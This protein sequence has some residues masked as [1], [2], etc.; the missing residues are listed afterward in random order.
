[1]DTINTNLTILTDSLKENAVLQNKG[2]YGV[3]SS[4]TNVADEYSS[5]RNEVGIIDFSAVGKL[6]IT[7]DEHVE[8]FNSLISFDIEFLDVEKTA[9]S[10]MLDN[11]GNVIDLITIYKHDDYILV[12]TSVSK[13]ARVLEY[14]NAYKTDEIEIVDESD[15]LAV[16]AFEG[17]YAWKLGQNLIDFDISSLPFQSFVETKWNGKDILFSRTGVTGEYGYRVFISVNEAVNLWNYLVKQKDEDYSVTPVGMDALNITMLEVRQ[18]NIE[19]EAKGLSV[20]E[21]CFEWLIS[22]DKEE[23]VA[24]D[25]INEQIEQGVK[26]RLVGFKFNSADELVPSD[27]IMVE[28][29]KV[30]EVLQVE[31]SFVL[32]QN[33]GL[34]IIKNEF[35]VSGLTIEGSGANGRVQIQ[36]ASSPYITPKSWAIKIV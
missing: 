28:D 2:G 24:M 25:V 32:E 26:R 36:T 20:F 29:E 34:A 33:L 22:F 8:F 10:L 7:G 1:M 11:K 21:S 15:S 16:I 30:G 35:A 12:E 6:R 19:F 5:L 4:Y 18:P 31:Y 27:S 23:F 13:R 17:P 3:I 9:F 14:L